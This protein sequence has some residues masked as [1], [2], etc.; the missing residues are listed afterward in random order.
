MRVVDARERV[1]SDY[2]YRVSHGVIKLRSGHDVLTVRTHWAAYNGHVLA[3]DR[4]CMRG[5]QC[6]VARLDSIQS[7]IRGLHQELILPSAAT[8][9]S[10]LQI[11]EW[12]VR[13]D[14]QLISLRCGLVC[15]Q[16][17]RV[18]RE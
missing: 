13:Y 12:A 16:Y 3:V 8:D 15:Q 7:A 1:A 14:G 5:L 18:G 6:S 2:G 17:N 11:H 10:Q 9:R 4:Q